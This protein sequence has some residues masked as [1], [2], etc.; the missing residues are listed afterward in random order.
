M[1]GEAEIVSGDFSEFPL[2]GIPSSQLRVGAVEPGKWAAALKT[3]TVLP[4][5][6]SSEFAPDLEATLTTAMQAAVVSLRE[7]LVAAR[8]R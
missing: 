5:L 4:S 8:L 2:A 7:L 3:G 6:H 1:E